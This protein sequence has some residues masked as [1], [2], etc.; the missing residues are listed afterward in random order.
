MKCLTLSAILL[1]LHIA[2]LAQYD[3]HV[4]ELTDK[5]GTSH[6]L[7]NPATYLSAKAIDR[8]TRQKINIDSTDLPISAAYL[9]SIR[10]VPDVTIIS[11]SK[12]LNQVLIPTDDANALSKINSFPFVRS[13][14]E[15]PPVAKP[16][17]QEPVM[18]KFGESLSPTDNREVL[19][20][21]NTVQQTSSIQALNYGNTFNQI[22]IHVAEYLHE[23]R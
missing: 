13:T 23:Q 19:S 17:T 16:S 5:K 6:T 2:A 1:F 15:I 10:N 9:D 20:R 14:R 22:H 3:R 11:V 8:R 4:V 21:I 12:W 18:R 7:A